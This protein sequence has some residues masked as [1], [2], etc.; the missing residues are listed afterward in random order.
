[1]SFGKKDRAGARGARDQQKF[2]QQAIDELKRQF[3][4]AQEGITPFIE[5]GKGALGDVIEGATVEGLDQRIAQLLDTDI[6]GSLVEERQRG[7]QGQLAA[8]GLTRSGTAIQE[9]AAIPTDIALAL[10]NILSGRQTNLAAS[11]QNAALGLGGL[12]AQ[13]ASGIANL[14]N[15]SGVAKAQGR[16]T[17]A[18]TRA[19]AIGNILN[20]GGTLGGAALGNPSNSFSDPR[21]KEDIEEIGEVYQHDDKS[22]SLK[23][24]Q[25]N[26]IKEAQGTLI[27]SCP[28]MGFLST[29]VKDLFPEFI[30]EFGGFDVIDYPGL[31]DKLNGTSLE[32][33]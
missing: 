3:G 10:E 29:E 28:T 16:I 15:A 8:G 1:M 23:V 9:A 27:E 18:N 26:W 6:F 25:W 24:H 20:L 33:A 22:K 2:N 31:L 30:Y 14:L 5:A 12:G 7:V 11:G 32:A 4:I 19:G 13:S 17:D 21:L